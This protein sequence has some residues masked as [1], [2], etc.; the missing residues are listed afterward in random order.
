MAGCGGAGDPA[1]VSFAGQPVITR[2]TMAHWIPI[3]SIIS[4][5]LLP[6]QPPPSGEVPDPPSYTACIAYQKAIGPPAN[7]DLPKPTTAQARQQ[8]I[9]RYEQTRLHLVRLL[10]S[11]KWT[12]VEAQSLGIHISQQELQR[13]WA[14]N[15]LELFGT[16]KVFQRYLAVTGETAADELKILKF[17]MQASKIQEKVLRE[18]GRAGL[19][20]FDREY[21]KELAAKTSCAAGW[22]IPDCRQYKGPQR[23][24]G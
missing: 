10:L 2:A 20:R 5:S 7:V 19:R 21:P 18:R 24:E 16:E 3:Q 13:T 22:I 4:R 14:R 15:K 1:L 9:A 6:Q 23:P 11:Y 17:D 12:E 8:C